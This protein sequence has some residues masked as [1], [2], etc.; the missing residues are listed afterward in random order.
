[1]RWNARA[2]FRLRVVRISFQIYDE[3][4]KLMVNKMPFVRNAQDEIALAVDV[5]LASDE[6]FLY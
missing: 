3:Y 6:K 2:H 4:I 1:M 5:R